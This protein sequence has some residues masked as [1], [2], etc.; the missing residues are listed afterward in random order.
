MRCQADYLPTPAEI[1]AACQEIRASWSES[2]HR[3]RARGRSTRTNDR[4]TAAPHDAPYEIPVV[5]C[6]AL[7]TELP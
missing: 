7:E 5:S 4:G 6:P 2:E 3:L 1:T